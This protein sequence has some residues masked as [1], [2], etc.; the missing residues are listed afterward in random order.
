MQFLFCIL[1]VT[2]ILIYLGMEEALSTPLHKP[3]VQKIRPPGLPTWRKYTVREDV[4]K[5]P[6]YDH[7]CNLTRTAVK[8]SFPEEM[9]SEIFVNLLGYKEPNLIHLQRCKGRC[10]DS[11]SPLTC[12]AT[13]VK[14]RKVKMT[15]RSYLTGKEPVDKMKELILDEHVECGCQ[16]N[17]KLASDCSGRFNSV[18]C[19]CECPAQEF[20]ERK[21]YCELRRDSFWDSKNC[22]CQSKT[23]AAREAGLGDPVCDNMAE[24]H[25]DLINTFDS[26]D[27]KAIDMLAWVML[28]SSL[29]L[30]IALSVT[31]YHYRNKVHVTERKY[32]TVK[33]QQF[34]FEGGDSSSSRSID[35]N[36]RQHVV[37][38][39]T[40]LR[41][42]HLSARPTVIP[43]NAPDLDLLDDGILL[44]R[45]MRIGLGH[46]Q[47]STMNMGCR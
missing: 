42:I 10:T 33:E 9:R 13:R 29:T 20:G 17:H 39:Y 31:T 5:A 2:S 18:T 11:D 14:E 3:L 26:S 28:G 37:E 21:T 41:K 25:L 12:R 27:D 45:M 8:I 30:V 47:N 24:K 46:P 16:C 43:V 4:E 44:E 36:S 34:T 7:A 19:G 38:E 1:T 15:I 40:I 6:T 35:C 23:I 32:H 22:Q